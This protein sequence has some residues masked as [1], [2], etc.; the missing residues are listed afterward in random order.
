M[1]RRRWRATEVEHTRIERLALVRNPRR[2]WPAA[3]LARYA[4][5]RPASLLTYWQGY[6][7]PWV[8]PRV[9]LNRRPFRRGQDGAL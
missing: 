7:A 4:R 1:I 6:G 9:R 8:S 5:P 3:T 2:P